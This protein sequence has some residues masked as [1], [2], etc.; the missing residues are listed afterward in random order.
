MSQPLTRTLLIAPL[1][2]ALATGSSAIAVAS[3]DTPRDPAISEGVLL[4]DGGE[5]DK[6][7]AKYREVLAREPGN[8]TALYEM[9]LSYYA[10][11]DLAAALEAA[12][13][14]VRFAD[15][16]RPAL[17]VLI[18][19]VR[20]EKGDSAGAIT[21]YRAGIKE[22]PKV[23]QLHLNL[24]VTFFRQKK[25]KDARL[26]FQQAVVLKPN[27]PTS[28]YYLAHAYEKEGFK[29]P[30]LLALTRFLLLEPGPD[31]SKEA[32][33]A[34]DRLFEDGYERESGGSV[35]LTLDPKSSREE[36][37]FQS[38]E[39]GMLLTQAASALP[40]EAEPAVPLPPNVKRLSE[41]LAIVAE[42]ADSKARGFAADFYLPYFTAIHA[43]S[44][45]EVASFIA[46]QASGLPEVGTW[47]TDHKKEADAFRAWSAAFSWPIVAVRR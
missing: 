40:D 41:A 25:W 14:G 12:E 32:L 11:K 20:D 34:M 19:N 18:G 44:R 22:D 31:R 24:G 45:V 39:L 5:Y 1:L 46:L 37:N 35:K 21:A 43:A 30:A 28:H 23:A 2:V 26:S 8:V 29:V 27:H 42:S 7:I 16:L 4:H 17:Y 10:K 36:G 33:R 38:A 47:L 6:A 15:P 9:A 3:S 13:A